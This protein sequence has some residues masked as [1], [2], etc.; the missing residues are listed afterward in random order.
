MSTSY[1]QLT[2]TLIGTAGSYQNKG[3]TIA[4]AVTGNPQDFFDGPTGDG[5]WV[6][7]DLGSQ[8]SP[9]SVSFAPRLGWSGYDQ[10]M[11]GGLIQGANKADFSDALDLLT[12]AVA[13]K[14]LA[15]YPLSGGSFRYVRYLSP[16]GGC[17][18]ISCLQFFGTQVA[19][20][21]SQIA[22]T[23]GG[24]LL[25]CT[26][27]GGNP[28]LHPQLLAAAKHFGFTMVR[29]WMEGSLLAA[30][31]SQ[32][33][34]SQAWAAA[35]VSVIAVLNFQ[36]M[37]PRCAAP[38]DSQWTI[39]LNS[40]PA[41]AATGV[42]YIEIGNELDY[43]T[44]YTGTVAQYAHLLA[45]AEPILHAKGY[46]IIMANC[47]YGLSWYQQLAALGA[48]AYVDAAGRHSYDSTAAAALANYTAAAAFV[49]SQGVQFLC[50]EVNLERVASGQLA[51][52][53]T[54]LY[55]GLANIPGSYI[56]FPLCVI[57]TDTADPAGLL[58]TAYAV[59]QPYY[60]ALESGLG[61]AVVS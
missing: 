29:L 45:L 25:G 4:K 13:P 8:F 51:S 37:T 48:F 47:L 38:S 42:T 54:K 20:T 19:H 39:Y 26:D 41:S 57:P 5:N 21:D 16:P 17:G 18:N 53:I 43:A 60:A 58:T 3:N 56:Y 55:A 32:W 22:S 50:T 15:A 44:Y 10:R 33:T 49:S 35:G 1:T 36:N 7:Y 30:C 27:A 28:S 31:E 12:I 52:E 24:N 46:R 9:T 6:G 11:V 14:A 23:Y 61:I 59:N 40:I 2:G 34:V